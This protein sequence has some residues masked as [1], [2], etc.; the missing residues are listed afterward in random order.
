M[1]TATSTVPASTGDFTAKEVT[2][3][4]AALRF[5]RL[6]CGTWVTVAKALRMRHSTLMNVA[7]GQKSVSAK[8]AVRIAK[9]AKVGVDDVLT[10]R[11]PAPGTCPYCGHVT[12]V[13]P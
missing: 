1:T 12:N 5:L 3:V 7:N 6:R 11:F 9:F 10:G 13:D 8:L 2:H 4:R